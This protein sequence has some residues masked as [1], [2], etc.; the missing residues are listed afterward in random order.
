MHTI[1]EEKRSD[2]LLFGGNSR[3][4]KIEWTGRP[5]AIEVYVH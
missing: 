1:L 3:S 4:Y 2:D 5:Q